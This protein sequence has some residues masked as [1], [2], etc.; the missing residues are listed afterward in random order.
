MTAVCLILKLVELCLLLEDKAAEYGFEFDW[1]SDAAMSKSRGMFRTAGA[2]AAEFILQM[3]AKND[4]C[5]W[6]QQRT[7]SRDQVSAF[8]QKILKY[9]DL[10]E[11]PK[12]WSFPSMS[13]DVAVPDDVKA[14]A[15]KLKTDGVFV[16]G[17]INAAGIASMHLAVTTPS[18]CSGL[19]Y[20]NQSSGHNF[21]LSAVCTADDAE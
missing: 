3:E 11:A 1:T 7:W 2:L 8:S 17:L 6:R 19:H 21:L 9:L 12:V 5:H 20:S 10:R 18:V 13:C 16:E 4:R 15:R 14:V